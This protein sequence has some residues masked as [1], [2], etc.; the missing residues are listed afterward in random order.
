MAD[1]WLNCKDHDL[2]IAGNRIKSS[3]TARAG[4]FDGG[5][6]PPGPKPEGWKNGRVPRIAEGGISKK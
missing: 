5:S 3:R 4:A 6:P 2:K 1:D